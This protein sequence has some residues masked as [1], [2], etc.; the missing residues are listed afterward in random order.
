MAE[1]A[2]SHS[3]KLGLNQIGYATLVVCIFFVVLSIAAVGLR[4][5]TRRMMGN[6]LGMDDWLVIASVFVFLGFCSNSLVG[7]YTYGGGQVYTNELEAQKKLT[8]YM[9]SEYAVPPLYAV[10]VTLVKI[11]ILCFYHRIFSVA[12]FRRINYGVGIFCLVWFVAAFIGDLL[13]CIPIRHFW[14]PTVA[15]HCFNFPS[16]FLAMELIDILLDVT[17]IVL[18]LRTISSL[19]LSFRKKVALLGVFLL[20]SF[21]IVTGA[22]RIAYVYRPGDD[23]RQA[24]LWSVINLG[25]AILCA[26]LPIYRPLLPKFG[27]LGSLVRSYYDKPSKGDG[28]HLPST[29]SERSNMNSYESRSANYYKMNDSQSDA[30]PLTNIAVGDHRSFERDL[31]GIRVQREVEVV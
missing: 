10:N 22:V 6:R 21:V 2:A 14:D 8:Q 11:S 7:V 15:G 5:A 9:K 3:Y 4:I 17:I 1:A 23:L 13:Y 26:C 16:Y 27:Q 18:P 30:L 20:G 12:S 28:S 31:Q 24:S 19:Q 25:V 29:N